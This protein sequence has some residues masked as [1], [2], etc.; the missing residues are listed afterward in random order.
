MDGSHVNTKIAQDAL[1][2]LG[3]AL[4]I[5]NPSK[6]E[7]DGTIQRFEYCYELIWK[8]ARR[9]L[10]QNEIDADVPKSIFRELGRLGWINNV[11]DWMSFQKSRNETSHEYGEKLAQKSYQLAQYFLPLAQQVLKVLESKNHE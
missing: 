5:K 2:N 11:E 8:L 1:K 6:L 9:V 3:E 4:A 7:R 10:K